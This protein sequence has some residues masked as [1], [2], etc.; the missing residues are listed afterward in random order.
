MNNIRLLIEFKKHLVSVIKN[1]LID[2]NIYVS[3][4][5]LLHNNFIHDI[6]HSINRPF[7]RLLNYSIK[8]H[9]HSIMVIA[10]S[11][12]SKEELKQFM[13][14]P[15]I[16]STI[17][18]NVRDVNKDNIYTVRYL[19]EDVLTSIIN[20]NILED[21]QEPTLE[22]RTRGTKQ[23]VNLLDK[24]FLIDYGSIDSTEIEV[25]SPEPEPEPEP[26]PESGI[27]IRY[28]EEFLWNEGGYVVENQEYTTENIHLTTQIAGL[29][30]V[31]ATMGGSG[32]TG[33][34][35]NCYVARYPQTGSTQFIFSVNDDGFV[36]MVKVIFTAESDDLLKV[37]DVRSGYYSGNDPT[38]P[39]IATSDPNQVSEQWYNSYQVFVADSDTT[40]AYGIKN[41]K[42]KF[43]FQPEPEPE[44]IP[45]PEPQPEPHHEPE[46][47]DRPEIIPQVV[48]VNDID[49]NSFLNEWITLDD[50]GIPFRGVWQHSNVNEI[51]YV[52]QISYTGLES[53]GRIYG[54]MLYYNVGEYLTYSLSFNCDIY[55]NSSEDILGIVFGLD[56][57]TRASYRLYISS[58]KYYGSN[59]TLVLIDENGYS[60]II[61]SSITDINVKT[62][63]KL[64]INVNEYGIMKCYL[65]NKLYINN[66]NTDISYGYIGLFSSFAKEESTI[67]NVN[68]LG[69]PYFQNYVPEPEPE[70]DIQPEAE[71]D[72]IPEP[73]P[74]PEPQPEL[75]PQPEPGPD[76]Y[77]ITT[78]AGSGPSNE[79][80]SGD[81][82]EAINAM[83]NTPYAC[84][85][86]SYG[87]LFIADRDNNVIRVV[88]KYTSP[89]LQICLLDSNK[90][91]QL[92][93]NN[94][95][96]IMGNGKS[97]YSISGTLC[98]KALLSK[99]TD[100]CIDSNNNIYV[101]L[102]NDNVIQ[103]IDSTTSIIETYCGE[104]ITT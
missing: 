53:N 3:Q 71:P 11:T 104:F 10:D 70:T 64:S 52:S 89:L 85:F 7:L 29:F 18:L 103:K 17:N 21:G 19:G 59:I 90:Y 13:I 26:Q 23:V 56:I 79:G 58:K 46:P 2:Q 4:I 54:S 66:K 1:A 49:Y 39:I 67:S 27:N 75:E 94:I 50:V 8:E 62:L 42:L 68:V 72:A 88:Y 101:P 15:D 48:I 16:G 83:L 47:I 20:N 86:D 95:Y 45:E 22:L 35:I 76:K 100:I 12:I 78:Y 63:Y 93:Y 33:S 96:T 36:K 38:V 24:T 60:K 73:E 32:V 9:D 43:E 25:D 99:P 84:S 5:H 81:G 77:I 55:L 44:P 30:A 57:I 61:G 102:P 91:T 82:F 92:E 69:V 41:L 34:G 87:N 80:Y 74:S 37:S 97:G 28:N 98:Y 31:S 6:S 40:E 65:N 14:L 51:D